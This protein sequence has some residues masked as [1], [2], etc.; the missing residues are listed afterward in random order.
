[1]QLCACFCRSLLLVKRNRPPHGGFLCSSRYEETQETGLIKSSP[2]NIYLK[3][4]S[5]S[6]SQSTEC[7]ISDLHPELLSGC[8][9]G[10]QW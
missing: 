2:E 3:A 1:M 7:L 4:Y 10:Q 8:V 5:P 6:F 9:E